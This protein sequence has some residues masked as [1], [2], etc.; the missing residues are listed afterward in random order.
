MWSSWSSVAWYVHFACTGT[1]AT[2]VKKFHIIYEEPCWTCVWSAPMYEFPLSTCNIFT[3]LQLIWCPS[4]IQMI[5]VVFT[6]V[7]YINHLSSAA[8]SPGFRYQV[9]SAQWVLLITF[10]IGQIWLQ[11]EDIMSYSEVADHYGCCLWVMRSSQL[12]LASGCIH[13]TS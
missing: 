9:H 3:W 13:W 4:N 1:I 11:Y 12:R 8:Y 7:K 5:M 2:V 10:Q 6:K